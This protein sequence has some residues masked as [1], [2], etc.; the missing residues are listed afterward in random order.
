MAEQTQRQLQEDKYH[1]SE[2]ERDENYAVFYSYCLR[3]WN[4]FKSC[5]KMFHLDNE[6]DS[7]VSFNNYAHSILNIV[8]KF[9]CSVRIKCYCNAEIDPVFLGNEKHLYAD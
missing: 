8:N 7:T 5:S 6:V 2:K 1:D 9:L 4:L 3:C